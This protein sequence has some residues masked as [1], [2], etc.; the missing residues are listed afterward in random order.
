[1]TRAW[2]VAA[3]CF[4]YSQLPM[5]GYMSRSKAILIGVAALAVVLIVILGRAY[6]QRRVAANYAH[7][8]REKERMQ[9]SNGDVPPRVH[10]CFDFNWRF[11]L[12]DVPEA[13]TPSF[14]DSSWRQ[15]DVPHD[16]SVEGD[17]SSTN[18]S[19][20]GY[21]PGGIAW[22]R[23]TFTVP[24]QWQDKIVAVQFEG[25]S[26]K[27]EVWLNGKSVGGRPWAYTTFSC[28]LTP[29]L[30]FGGTNVLAVR[31][32]HSAMDDTRYYGGSGIYRHV[33][34]I[35]TERLH[36]GDDGVFVTTPEVSE[37]KA[38]VVVETTVDD[39]VAA[40]DI[41]LSTELI[42]PGGQVVGTSRT[43][44]AV[45][46]EGQKVL[47]QEILLSSPKL[48]SPDSPSLYTAVTT[49]RLGQ[50]II[51]RLDTP[52]GIR[53]IQFDPQKGFFLNGQPMKFKGVCLHHTAGALG[54]A[55]PEATDERRL[56]LLK[57]VGCNAIRTSHNEPS[58]EFLDLCDQHGFLVMDEAFDEWSGSKK[59]WVFGRNI[60]KPSLYGGYSEFFKK[61]ADKDMLDMVRRDRNHPSVIL[62]SIGN[63]MDY[64]NDPYTEKTAG[65]LAKDARR[66][67]EAVRKGD[68]TRPITAALG[69]PA[70]AERIGLED[71]L[72]VVGYNYQLDQMLTDMEA[73]PNRK[74]IG[75]EE[76]YHMD[77]ID[78]LATNRRLAGQ[79]LWLGFD[80][81][82]EAVN[83]PSH[84]SG[85]GMFNTCGFLK[86]RGAFRKSLWAEKPMVYLAVQDSYDSDESTRAPLGDAKNHWN[87]KPGTQLTV[88][89]YCNCKS[90]ELFLNGKSLG[91]KS[92]ADAPNRI[93]QWDVVFEPGEL[94]AVVRNGGGET[95]EYRLRTAGPPAR[96]EIAPDK[97][98][99]TQDRDVAHLELRLV[100]TN[101][102]VVPD[103]NGLCT[104]EITG[105][106]RLRALDNGDQSDS[107]PL[108]SHSRRFNGGRALA[109]VQSLHDQLG[110]IEVTVATAGV[111][112]AR[113]KLR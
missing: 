52:F 47:S 49:L 2:V 57:E 71:Q 37:Q 39:E 3:L 41:D 15:L 77:Y 59:K 36:I 72:D 101:G 84:G 54:A 86:P 53:S 48:W 68:T 93:P 28:D 91:T 100:D 25:V 81:L 112:E 103:G 87:W 110:P 58:P 4:S 38:R 22:Y 69:A 32:D 67:I 20:S 89:C 111:P 76:D 24:A 78:L 56:R 80:I 60:G 31:V 21:L 16:F 23:K 19:C 105:P 90:V 97:K 46:A 61:W 43:N 12:G 70:R 106:A 75:S 96:I 104:V 35:A 51:D 17:F 14:D 42:G 64:P 13:A 107:T 65:V 109:I 27:G 8:E 26:A 85:S 30:K 9:R 1:M 62:W 94:K 63:E 5:L 33:W 66:L 88:E 50:R 74:F 44:S 95:V 11:H 40:A 108:R 102:V 7:L 82:G 34:L 73:H 99:L 6:H 113:I 45:E 55:V 83:W 10:E 79:F 29:Y 92:P 98:Q 18:F